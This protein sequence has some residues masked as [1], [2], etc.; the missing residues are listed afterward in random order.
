MENETIY[1]RLNAR[2]EITPETMDE[3]EGALLMAA[4]NTE[5]IL[6]STGCYPIGSTRTFH[7][8]PNFHESYTFRAEITSCEHQSFPSERLDY[9]EITAKILDEAPFLK[10]SKALRKTS[11]EMNE[12]VRLLFEVPVTVS[13]QDH[14]AE[15]TCGNISYSGLFLNS[16]L[17]KIEP[18]PG[19]LI[20][21]HLHFK[22]EVGTFETQGNVVY[23]IPQK[24]ATRLGIKAGIGIRLQQDE[25]QRLRWEDLVKQFHQAS[26]LSS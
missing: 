25:E 13:H 20:D 7:G 24:Q 18:Q 17:P 10:F 22:D 15:T 23:S 8:D 11:F 9:H 19:D 4:S 12:D 5:M 6:R 2:I 21:I 26:F 16:P 14:S 1:V 3:P